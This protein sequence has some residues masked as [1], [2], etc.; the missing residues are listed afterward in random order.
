VYN[1]I[2]P[3]AISNADFYRALAKALHRPY[4]FRTPAFLLRLVLGEM[5]VLVV[6]GRFSRPRRL[7]EAGFKF[8][9]EGMGD[10]M[11]RLVG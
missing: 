2:A 3:E 4:W 9:V 7:Q 5:S 11:K 6:D 8:Q 10:V 1:L